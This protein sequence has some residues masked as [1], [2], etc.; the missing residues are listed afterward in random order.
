M[1]IDS[2]V[3]FRTRTEDIKKIDS[4]ILKL[5]QEGLVGKVFKAIAVGTHCD[6]P[7]LVNIGVDVNIRTFSAV[8]D[9]NVRAYLWKSKEPGVVCCANTIVHVDRLLHNALTKVQNRSTVYISKNVLCS[10]L[11]NIDLKEFQVAWGL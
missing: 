7:H 4:H 1:D 11:P 2:V 3:R 6:G 5:H 10:G 9:L 8:E